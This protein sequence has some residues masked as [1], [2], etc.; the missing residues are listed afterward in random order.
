MACLA[1]SNPKNG[2]FRFQAKKIGGPTW[3]VHEKQVFIL[4]LDIW[5]FFGTQNSSKTSQKHTGPLVSAGYLGSIFSDHLSP[6]HSELDEA[7][8]PGSGEFIPSGSP[9]AQDKSAQESMKAQT[10]HYSLSEISWCREWCSTVVKL[11][12]LGLYPSC[13]SFWQQS[14]HRLESQNLDWL[15][16][17]LFTSNNCSVNIQPWKSLRIS[18]STIDGGLTSDEPP[19]GQCKTPKILG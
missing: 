7:F 15:D 2:C 19:K 16:L 3:W 11:N 12:Y 17:Y 9:T 10:H 8:S 4:H 6:T 13:A 5:Y 1:I 14:Q 18:I